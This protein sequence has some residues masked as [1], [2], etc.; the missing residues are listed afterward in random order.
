MHAKANDDSG[1]SF[2]VSAGG[3]AG[4]GAGEVRAPRGEDGDSA[5][6]A[7]RFGTGAALLAWAGGAAFASAGTEVSVAAGGA[8]SS[9][10]STGPEPESVMD[11]GQ[12]QSV[13]LE[14]SRLPHL[15][16]HVARAD[17]H[18]DERRPAH[19]AHEP[20]AT[21]LRVLGKEERR[22]LGCG[23]GGAR[24]GPRG[25][26]RRGALARLRH[27]LRVGLVGHGGPARR[28]SGHLEQADQA[29][30][31]A[32][33]LLHLAQA[34][35]AGG[36]AADVGLYLLHLVQVQLAVEQGVQSAFVK[37]RHGC[38][39]PARDTLR[40]VSAGRAPAWCLPPLSRVRAW[41]RSR[42]T[43]SPRP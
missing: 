5:R 18:E 16:A 31:L 6:G 43:R 40:P 8:A 3:G 9:V 21:V 2:A 37:M 32:M 24:Q 10:L 27:R 41:K 26:R 20:A 34:G 15:I 17:G 1:S 19:A 7:T 4:A 35:A 14:A 42:R 12:R 22:R 23:P 39:V 36:A 29:V 30:G 38:L 25:P 28:S 13:E 11:L 33:E